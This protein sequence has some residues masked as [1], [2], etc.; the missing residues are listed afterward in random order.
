MSDIRPDILVSRPKE[1][2]PMKASCITM[3]ADVDL[4]KGPFKNHVDNRGWVGGLK[5]AIFVHV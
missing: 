3:K 1:H 4:T 5:F 2:V